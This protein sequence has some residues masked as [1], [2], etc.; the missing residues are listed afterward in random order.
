MR[1]DNI[2]AVNIPGA[3]L[4]FTKTNSLG[5]P[6]KGRSL[7]HIGF[8]TSDLDKIYSSWIGAG[9]EFETPPRIG[10]N[11]ITRVAFC[12]DPWGTRIELTE[13]ISAL[14]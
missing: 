4:R 14:L 1:I 12:S 9:V 3:E 2:F 5:L 7:D 11:G 8:E 13:K 10:R 6:T